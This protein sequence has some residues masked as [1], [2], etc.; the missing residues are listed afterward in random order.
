MQNFWTPDVNGDIDIYV[1]NYHCKSSKAPKDKTPGFQRLLLVP[2]RPWHH[3]MARFKYIPRAK[4]G[5]GNAFNIIDK[6]TKKSL[7]KGL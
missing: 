6:L 4:D 2:K 1:K 5:S 7:V 3:I